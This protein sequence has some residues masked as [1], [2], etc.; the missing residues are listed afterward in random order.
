MRNKLLH[1]RGTMPVWMMVLAV[2]CLGAVSCQKKYSPMDSI[3]KMA[4]KNIPGYY[5][6]IGVDS[7]TL[8]ASLKEYKL[9]KGGAGVYRESKSGDGQDIATTSQ[10][11]TW[12]RGEFTDG[13]SFVNMFVNFENGGSQALKWG[14]AALF[15]EGKTYGSGSKINNLDAIYADFAN[16]AFEK[17]DSAFFTRVDTVL[18]TY[19]AWT[20]AKGTAAKLTEEQIAEKR[21]Y[22]ALQWV[23]DTIAWFNA[24]HLPMGSKPIPDSIAVGKKSGNTYI[25]VYYI[26]EERTDS[27]PVDVHL[28][29]K[30]FTNSTFYFDRDASFKN[31]G[32]YCHHYFRQDSAHYLDPTAANA[33]AKDS[34]SMFVADSWCVGTSLG[35]SAFD[36]VARG[37]YTYKVWETVNGQKTVIA[38]VVT[39]NTI[40]VFPISSFYK[41]EEATYNTIKHNYM[42][43]HP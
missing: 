31:T 14:S 28:A 21:E 7:A 11:V 15:F 23:K 9:E 34:L 43:V 27:I 30:E 41:N 32:Y 25:C 2:L 5:S 40:K 33:N 35:T 16:Q 38:D 19:L 17:V 36:I 13:N 22:F 24:N 6:W 20:Q 39:P 18:D 8:V 42:K 12:S 29:N 37:T 10:N 1:S 3:E 4:D 26:G